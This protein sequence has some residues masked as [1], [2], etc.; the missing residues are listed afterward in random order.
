VSVRKFDVEAWRAVE[1]AV[2]LE[3]ERQ[4]EEGLP[5]E[6][7]YRSL[8][9]A[10]AQFIYQL[11][12]AA[13]AKR[14]VEVGTS[15]GY[16]TLWLARACAATGGSVLTFERNEGIVQVA[17]SH[18]EL[19][20]VADLVEVI[21]GDARETLGAFAGPFELA[22]VDG[23]KD[24]YVAYGEILWPR[25]AAGGSMV[26]DNVVSHAEAAAPFMEWLFSLDGAATTI[27]EIGRG[28][29]WTVKGGRRP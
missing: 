4:R 8:H 20:G 21:G 5:P 10:S 28:L 23:E 27:L 25:L 2:R 22:F 24:E 1:E 16:S 18:F 26:A 14:V 9:P 6:K 7:R 19:A 29:A 17:K 12:L 13:D 3:N 15:A 11:A